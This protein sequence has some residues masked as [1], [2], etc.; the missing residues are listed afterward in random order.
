[1]KLAGLDA[2]LRPNDREEAY[3]IQEATARALG[4]IAGWKT[5]AAAATATAEFAPIFEVLETPARL[6][7][8]GLS[9]YAIEAEL[10]FRLGRDLPA[11]AA[12]YGWEEILAAIASL[13]PAIEAVESRFVDVA[14]AAPLDRLADNG[15]NAALIL[16]PAL[17]GG[18]QAWQA[19]DLVR[20]PI[21][22]T[23]DGRLVAETTGNSGGDPR[24]LVAALVE[25]CRTRDG[26]RA[27]QAI[28]TGSCTGLTFAHP[29]ATII[30]D[31]GAL[32]A[33]R[34]DFGK[35]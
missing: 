23:V 24:R 12:P 18:P 19:L 16:G 8:R 13:H 33:V 4:P 14:A 35:S 22:V 5:G 3:A 1:V 30:A 21:T 26:M 20:P 25:H 15:S 2:S 32:G 28:T 34:L 27:G 17:S 6:S 11:R 7:A 29:G 10:A 9:L 31:Y